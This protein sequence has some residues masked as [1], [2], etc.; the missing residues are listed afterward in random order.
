MLDELGIPPNHC[1][2]KTPNQ[3]SR[4]FSR[5]MLSVM[6]PPQIY[7]YIYI[8]IFVICYAFWITKFHYDYLFP[9]LAVNLEI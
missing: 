7:I 4:S 3:Y 5:A 9:R 2:L 1:L 8:F 6:A